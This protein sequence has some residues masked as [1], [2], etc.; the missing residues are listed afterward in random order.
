MSTFREEGRTS[1]EEG[2]QRYYGIITFFEGGG[3][4]GGSP[5]GHQS[6]T[7]ISPEAFTVPFTAITIP[8]SRFGEF[9]LGG[10]WVGLSSECQ[11]FG[12][13]WVWFGFGLISFG[14]A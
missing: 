6:S 12:V 10:G 13:V 4:G 2:Y 9:R 5:A 8:K 3:V 11:V 1:R 7:N 14:A